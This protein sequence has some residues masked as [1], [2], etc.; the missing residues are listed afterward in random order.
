MRFPFRLTLSAAQVLLMA[1]LVVAVIFNIPFLEQ[2]YQ[3]VGPNDIH[4]W[5]FI[6]TVPVV[7]TSLTVIFLTISGALFFPRLIISLTII[8]SAL[9]LYA[10]LVYGI[11]YDRSMIQ[12]VL[13]TN[14]GEAFSY[15]NL[16]FLCF[17]VVLGVIPVFALSNQ[18][19][20]GRLTQRTRQVLKVNA[21]AVASIVL[22]A[23]GFY[24]DY[25][26]VGRNNHTLTKYIIPYAFYDSGYKYLRDSYFYPPLAFRVLD[27]KPISG[28]RS[29]A[30]Y[31]TTVMVV[32]ETARADN[33]S[34]NGYP[35]ST[36]PLLSARS[37]I[38]SFRQVVSCGTATAV[39]VPCMF[40]RLAHEDYDSRIAESQDNV[41]DII[42][43]AGSEVTWIDN[44]SSCKGVCQRINTI[45]FDPA[46]D[47]KWCDGDYCLDDILLDELRAELARPATSDRL[48]VLHMIGSHGPTYYRRYPSQYRTF[49]P[50][51]P[52]SDIQNCSHE[53]L[54][55]TYDN[56]LVYTDHILSGVISQLETLPDASM[57]YLSDH[58]ESLGEKGLYLHGFPYAVAP[59]EQTHV[60]MIYWDS[61]LAQGRY[62]ACVESVS[63]QP[64]SQDNLYDTLL[65]LTLTHSSTYDT[66]SDIF[67]RCQAF[68]KGGEHAV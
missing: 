49:T 66:D 3:A 21:L 64:W 22:V 53:Q 68:S 51:C 40:S 44:N 45:D 13:E 29:G 19:I 9:L 23:A 31:K 14:S 39:S 38:V 12:N 20:K 35:R 50:D 62:K 47:P 61:R 43:R 52:R 56:T 24:Q 6:L 10:T 2:V 37:D 63:T 5:L 16:S 28:H 42:L 57:L 67:S 32:G 7:L 15:F 27:K 33:F 60:P 46:R 41:L 48:I 11:I 18:Q 36:N 8:I 55:N 34:L 54:I 1:S 26:A 25:A 59:A 58:G 30:P 4:S 65:G 17:L